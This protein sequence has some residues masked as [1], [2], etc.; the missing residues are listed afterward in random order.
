MCGGGGGWTAESGTGMGKWRIGREYR[1]EGYIYPI[2]IHIH[3]SITPS[4]SMQK[5]GFFGKKD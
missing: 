2:H 5:N 1:K 3:P 4:M